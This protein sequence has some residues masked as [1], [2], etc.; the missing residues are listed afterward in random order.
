[1][2]VWLA[3]YPRAGNTLLRAV[4]FRCFGLESYSDEIDSAVRSQV[5]LSETSE[6]LFGHREIDGE[7]ESFYAG[8]TASADVHLVKT[9]RA[10]RDQQKAV[11]VVR[12]GRQALVS[13]RRFH[14]DYLGD[15]QLSLLQLVLGLDHYGGWSEHYE[16]WT[17][18]RP[19]TLVVRF[20]DL[21][22]G[23]RV[24]LE[25]LSA[26]LGRQGVP[27]AWQNPMVILQRENPTFF[28]HGRAKW[29]G[30]PIWDELVDSAFF[31]LHGTLMTTLAYAEP[32]VAAQARARMLGETSELLSIVQDLRGRN[33][34]LAQIC[35]ERL[36]VIIGLKEACD[37]RLALIQ[38]LGSASVK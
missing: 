16:M 10:P 2:I 3:S 21:V 17:Q 4:L 12:D 24:T 31:L 29:E 26:H 19:G 7:W 23:D 5:A 18:D 13:Y 34:E 27:C 36:Q 6:N 20:E 9:H 22:G 35:S 8:A 15:Q 28:R 37:E 32:A 30:D 33:R 14:Q 25:G 1:V 11:Y 38:S